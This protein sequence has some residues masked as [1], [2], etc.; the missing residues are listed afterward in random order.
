MYCSR[1]FANIN[2]LS[3]Q[4]LPWGCQEDIINCARFKHHVLF[5]AKKKR[6]PGRNQKVWP[7]TLNDPQNITSEVDIEDVGDQPGQGE[8]MMMKRS[9]K[10]IYGNCMIDI[11][12][13]PKS[14]IWYDTVWYDMIWYDMIWYDMIWYDIIYMIYRE[15][16]YKHSYHIA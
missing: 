15:G 9:S 10:E 12:K 13:Y 8:K 3:K 4:V 2:G 7:P 6:H 5:T 11:R 14:Y 16:V 1:L